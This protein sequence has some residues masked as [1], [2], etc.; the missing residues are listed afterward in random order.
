MVEGFAVGVGLW[1]IGVPSAPLWGAL[2]ALSNFV[3]FVGPL[4]MTLVLFAVG[5][6][7]FDTLG[8]SLLPPLIYQA[9]NVVES[10]FFTPGVIGRTM[11]LNPF[12]VV[13]ALAFWIWM[14]GALGGFIAI[15]AL[16]ICYAIVR[17]IVPSTGWEAD[18]DATPIVKIGKT[19]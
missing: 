4:V 3:V 13:L 10:Q 2:A 14:W 19:R 8:G 9:I 11:T 12:L 16:L 1:L 18:E 15:P 17:N 5:L 6:S 7:E